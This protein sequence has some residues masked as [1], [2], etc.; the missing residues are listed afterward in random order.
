[1]EPFT[2]VRQ[3]SSTYALPSLSTTAGIQLGCSR[4]PTIPLGPTS[5]RIP[6]TVGANGG[7][8]LIGPID[9]SPLMQ[10]K[11]LQAI[12]WTRSAETCT[13]S[14]GPRGCSH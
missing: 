10:I 11:V 5:Y 12:R 14:I 8:R 6:S 4:E 9:L 7:S 13:K 1:M 2:A 3:R